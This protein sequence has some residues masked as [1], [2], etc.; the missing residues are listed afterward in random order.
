MTSGAGKQQPVGWYQSVRQRVVHIPAGRAIVLDLQQARRDR[1]IAS[2]GWWQPVNNRPLFPRTQDAP[3]HR[4]DEGQWWGEPEGVA[5]ARYLQLSERLAE[6][7]E[8][9]R[10]GFGRLS[11][12][13][14]C[15]PRAGS[16]E[17]GGRRTAR[18]IGTVSSWGFE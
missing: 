14:V 2:N 18:A 3:R 10:R 7:R 1:E 13:D 12:D 4:T 6:Q 5:D 9:C 16:E 15:G 11:S 8:R 17:R